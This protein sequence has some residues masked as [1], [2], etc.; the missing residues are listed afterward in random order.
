MLPDDERISW[1]EAER[2]VRLHRLRCDFPVDVP[3]ASLARALDVD[4]SE[5]TGLLAETRGDRKSRRRFTDR[6]GLV[7]AALAAGVAVAVIAAAAL[8]SAFSQEDV[9][10]AV[11]SSASTSTPAMRGPIVVLT[12][13][14]P[15]APGTSESPAPS[16]SSDSQPD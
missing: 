7:S 12:P 10:P 1:K 16:P 14:A 3:V 9:A 15:M 11:V 4:V 6:S 5:V 8:Y 2:V 13:P